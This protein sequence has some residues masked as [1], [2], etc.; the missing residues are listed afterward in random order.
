[1][2]VFKK[3][4]SLNLHNNFVAQVWYIINRLTEPLLRK[5]G[6]LVPVSWDEALDH[7]AERLLA[8]RRESGPEA[9]FHYRSGGSLGLLKRVTGEMF[10]RFGPV[11]LGIHNVA[12]C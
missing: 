11:K 6:E 7:V 10:D 3:I 4:Y 8:I 9:I 12:P 2:E 1:M 5:Q